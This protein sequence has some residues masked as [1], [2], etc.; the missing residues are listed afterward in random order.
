MSFQPTYFRQETLGSI[1]RDRKPNGFGGLYLEAQQWFSPESI[2]SITRIH[3]CV[4]QCPWRPCS[5]PFPS[6]SGYFVETLAHRK[7][8]RKGSGAK[9]EICNQ[10]HL[11]PIKARTTIKNMPVIIRKTQPNESKR[12]PETDAPA[13]PS[14]VRWELRHRLRRSLKTLV[15]LPARKI[16]TIQPTS[17]S[18]PHAAFFAISIAASVPPA[19]RTASEIP[20]TTTTPEVITSRTMPSTTSQCR[21]PALIHSSCH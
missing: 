3:L 2:L 1:R 15:I 13:R 7:E 18:M 14:S 19:V 20:I 6:P 11:F 16:R 9:H 10:D 17:P 12:T 8:H 4:H 21:G 5:R